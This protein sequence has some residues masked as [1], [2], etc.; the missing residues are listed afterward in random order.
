MSQTQPAK[1]KNVF[2]WLTGIGLFIVPA[3]CGA[4]TYYVSTSGNDANPG[5][6]LNAPFRTLK[7]SLAKLSAGDTLY[8]RG[9][10]Y[11]EIIESHNGANFP[12]GTSWSNP[13]T[14][15]PYQ[16]EQVTLYG[17]MSIGRENPLTQ[18][19]I[20][21]G[22]SFDGKGAIPYD[23]VS[24][25]GGSHHIR[26]IN[27]EVKNSVSTAGLSA[28]H[29]N[30]AN[31]GAPSFIEIINMDIHHNGLDASYYTE[32]HRAAHRHGL[33]LAISG[34]L[35]EGSRIHDNGGCGIHQNTSQRIKDTI[36][37]NNRIWNNGTCG[38]I[39]TGS[40]NALVSNNVVWGNTTGIAVSSIKDPKGPKVYNNT[41]Y[42]NSYQGINVSQPL[43]GNNGP[44]DTLVYNNISYNNLQ[45]LFDGGIN[46]TQ[47][48]NLLGI[49]PFFVDAGNRD[50][51]LTSQS[52]AR[53]AGRTLD[54]VKTDI[55]GR[56]RSKDGVYDIGAYE[57][58]DG[59]ITPPPVEPPRSEPPVVPE[60]PTL[61]NSNTLMTHSGNF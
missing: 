16:Q 27:G 8:M 58:G 51:H 6:A 17:R 19:L 49:N 57:F 21:D 18:Y 10:T 1:S 48:N 46:T 34:I 44:F 47:G 45:D 36:Y 3:L 23:A 59:E 32:V 28:N 11:N 35:V 20:F 56:L 33:Y 2:P 50:F 12:S 42:G 14:I 31:P 60:A 9:G 30:D 24:I 41:V 22:I 5:T 55:D 13:V 15:T 53:D 4:T 61:A 39:I 52:P 37:R 7:F 25:N 38:V 26:F 43:W 40:D 54:E 29:H